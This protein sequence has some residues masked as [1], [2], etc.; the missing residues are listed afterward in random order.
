M[1]PKIIAW[2]QDSFARSLLIETEKAL[3]FEFLVVLSA[4]I[5]Q[6]E[7][8]FN[9]ISTMLHPLVT[10]WANDQTTAWLQSVHSLRDALGISSLTSIG[11]YHLS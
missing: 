3:I 7:E 4:S 5:P 2:V 1:F 10:E 9:F 6:F 11:K 8:R